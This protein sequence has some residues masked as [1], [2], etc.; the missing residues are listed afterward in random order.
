MDDVT[1]RKMVKEHLCPGCVSDCSDDMKLCKMFGNSVVGRTCRNWHAGTTCSGMGSIALGM[2][3]G[4][5]RLGQM[6]HTKRAAAEC[7]DIML[8]RLFT[9]E[10]YD[11]FFKSKPPS[12]GFWDTPLTFNIPTWA[13]IQNGYLYVRTFAPRTAWQW[14]DV[15]KDGTLDL[16]P[17]AIDVGEFIDHID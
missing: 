12:K 4:F 5:N 17:Q 9:R 13:L 14:I 1:F 7:A 15:V 2:P 6:Q 10:E 16:V 8:I 11:N 3:K